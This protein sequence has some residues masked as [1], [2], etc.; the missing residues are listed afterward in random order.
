MIINE[1]TGPA[2]FHVIRCR[3]F[4]FSFHSFHLFKSRFTVFAGFFWVV[5]TRDSRVPK[6]ER[7][8]HTVSQKGLHMPISQTF[9]K[10]QSFEPPQSFK[11]DSITNQF[12][13]SIPKK[14]FFLQNH[15]K[16]NKSISSVRFVPLF[17]VLCIQTT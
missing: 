10:R 11:V 15:N 5:S 13:L 14:I 7:K 9:S 6:I 12:R 3:W 4:L 8:P 16:P 1:R 2:A 17:H